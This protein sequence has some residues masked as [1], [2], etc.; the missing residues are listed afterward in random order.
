MIFFSMNGRRIFGFFMECK[1]LDYTLKRIL[2]RHPIV[3][4]YVSGRK[5]RIIDVKYCERDP[6]DGD[7]E[8]KEGYQLTYDDEEGNFP[9]S[10]V[11]LSELDVKFTL[12][13]KKGRNFEDPD[14]FILKKFATLFDE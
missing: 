5:A 4:V 14:E 3:C 10:L 12:R 1:Q 7:V 13:E 6:R 11:E 8:K 2:R 9:M